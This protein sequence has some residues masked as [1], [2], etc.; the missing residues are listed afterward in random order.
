MQVKRYV[1][2]LSIALLTGF[3]EGKANSKVFGKPKLAMEI[4]FIAG[5]DGSDVLPTTTDDIELGVYKFYTSDSSITE[6]VLLNLSY[7]TWCTLDSFNRK[8]VLNYLKQVIPIV[9]IMDN[10][11]IEIIEIL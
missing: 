6:I 3:T 1:F 11:A 2:L 9:K 8:D 4:P 10:Q 5:I 7:Q